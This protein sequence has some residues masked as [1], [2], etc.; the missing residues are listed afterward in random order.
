MRMFGSRRRI[1]R[2]LERCFECGCA[3]ETPDCCVLCCAAPLPRRPFLKTARRRFQFG[4]PSGRRCGDLRQIARAHQRHVQ[5]ARNRRRADRQHVNIRAQRT[6]FFL[7]HYAEAVS[8]F[9][10][11]RPSSSNCT[12]FDSSRCG[13]DNHVH[14]TRRELLSASLLLALGLKTRDHAHVHGPV[15]EALAECADSA[16]APDRRGHQHRHLLAV[17]HGLES[18]MHCDLGFAV[19]TSP[20]I[21]RSIGIGFSMSRLTDSLAVN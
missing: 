17:G 18:R 7:L 5:R 13:A 8:S 9:M 11:R 14:V 4:R 12:S 1:P 10:I 2:R 20:Q 16:A 3:R 21:S 19:A 6:D 15:L